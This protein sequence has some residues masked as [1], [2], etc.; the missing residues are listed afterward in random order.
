MPEKPLQGR[1]ALV[2]G[3]NSPLGIG[4]ATATALSRAGARVFVHYWRFQDRLAGPARYIDASKSSPDEVLARIR[5]Y[6]GTAEAWEIDL[7]D[8]ANVVELMDRVESTLGPLDILVNNARHWEPD[9]FLLGDREAEARPS[10]LW[11]PPSANL[12]AESH[13]RHFSVNSRAVALLLGEYARRYLARGASW[14]RVVGLTTGG[15]AGFPRE[16]SYG[17]SKAALE[18]Y[19]RA[20]ARELGPYGVTA[21]CVEPGACQ[22]GW[23]E[24]ELEA[25]VAEQSPLRR[26]SRPEEVADL[27]VFLC[28]DRAGLLTGQCL[29]ALGG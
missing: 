16:V 1:V 24:P 25:A 9:T 27:I 2:T 4:G 14:G 10:R 19:T 21:N 23:I 17:A 13:D 29:R 12:C 5:E 11:P 22:T 18:S 26:V 3:A 20:F 28:S 15:S 7:A 8:P 6:G